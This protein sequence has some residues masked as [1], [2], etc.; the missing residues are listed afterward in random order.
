MAK[1]LTLTFDKAQFNIMLDALEER[2]SALKE[3][4]AAKHPA[5][6]GSHRHQLELEAHGIIQLINEIRTQCEGN[7]E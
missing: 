6:P 3:G 1:P 7:E 5:R 2:V 4:A